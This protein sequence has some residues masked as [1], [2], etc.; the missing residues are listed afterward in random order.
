MIDN[1]EIDRKNTIINTHDKMVMHIQIEEDFF[2]MKETNKA[3]FLVKTGYRVQK[4]LGTTDNYNINTSNIIKKMLRDSDEFD[5]TII[6]MIKECLNTSMRTA[7]VVKLTKYLIK[8]SYTS[9]D[10]ILETDDD[11]EEYYY[12]NEYDIF[13]FS[14]TNDDPEFDFIL[15]Q[16][17]DR[18]NGEF[19]SGGKL[20]TFPGFWLEFIGEKD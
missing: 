8:E 6:I 18:K 11:Y 12:S 4:I 10:E 13:G 3:N 5:D 20:Y 1:T 14:F 15:V 17:F 19:I 16:E 9:T 2:T 7:N